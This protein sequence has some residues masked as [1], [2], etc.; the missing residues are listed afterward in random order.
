MQRY[1]S[2]MDVCTDGCTDVR[3]G[4]YIH[5]YVYVPLCVSI[6]VCERLEVDFKLTEEE[7]EE[8]EWIQGRTTYTNGEANN[9]KARQ[10]RHDS[11][12]VSCM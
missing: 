12:Y 5:A 9:R 6:S 11:M 2:C 8:E 3:M 10:G 1:L 4:I 7:E